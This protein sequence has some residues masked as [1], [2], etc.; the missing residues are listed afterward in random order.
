MPPTPTWRWPRLDRLDEVV[1]GLMDRLAG[2]R[3]LARHLVGVLGNS[4]S[5]GRHLMAHPEHLD[6][7]D[8]SVEPLTAEDLRAELLQ[9]GR[10]RS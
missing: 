5:L 7:L 8:G 10:C 4:E 2:S 1:A 9:V 3:D 6:W